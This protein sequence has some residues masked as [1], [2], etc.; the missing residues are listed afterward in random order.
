[1]A[2]QEDG[3]R[4]GG[5]PCERRPVGRFRFEQYGTVAPNQNVNGIPREDREGRAGQ[6]I[7][8]RFRIADRCDEKPDRQQIAVD[9]RE[10]A[11]KDP[12]RREKPADPRCQE[13]LRNQQRGQVNTVSGT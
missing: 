10:V 2:E 5:E 4:D 3:D 1:M 11:D 13:N 8:T 12:Q 9:L 6:G 7:Q